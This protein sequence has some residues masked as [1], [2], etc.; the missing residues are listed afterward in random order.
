M[1]V[2]RK[3]QFNPQLH[4]LHFPAFQFEDEMARTRFLNNIAFVRLGTPHIGF[5][6]LDPNLAMLRLKEATEHLKD[7]ND[8]LR[9]KVMCDCAN[10]KLV[11]PWIMLV[12]LDKEISDVQF[13]LRHPDDFLKSPRLASTSKNCRNSQGGDNKEKD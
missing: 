4:N 9:I 13:F 8:R 6:K 11:S 12:H 1:K 2:I 5:I 10:M 7:E 3:L